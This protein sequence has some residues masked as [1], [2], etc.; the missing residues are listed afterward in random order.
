MIQIFLNQCCYTNLQL[1]NYS[2]LCMLLLIDL[3]ALQNP[4]MSRNIFLN[5]QNKV[6][7]INFIIKLLLVNYINYVIYVKNR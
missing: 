7:H 4:K 2:N 3:K 5:H 1:V 6:N